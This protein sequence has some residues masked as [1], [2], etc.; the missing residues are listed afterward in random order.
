MTRGMRLRVRWR[1]GVLIVWL[2]AILVPG[3]RWGA[4]V[5]QPS[6]GPSGPPAD[7]ILT[8]H[9]GLLSLRAEDASLKAIVEAIGQ[10]LSIEVVTRIPADERLTIAFDRL[11]L[12]EALTRLRPYVSYL[13]LEDATTAPGTIRQLIVVSKRL[14]GTP[15]SRPTQDGEVLASPS[16]SP[17]DAPTLTDTARPKPFRFEFDPT[18]GGGRGR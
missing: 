10:Q 4:E 12:P 17:R 1:G 18:T 14:A 7:F 5:A 16:P 13:V 15:S 6:P 3:E 8:G 11:S 9:E 2:L